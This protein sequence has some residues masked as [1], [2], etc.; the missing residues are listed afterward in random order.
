[1]RM[2]TCYENSPGR[3]DRS[4]RCNGCSNSS[5]HDLII[6]ALKLALFKPKLNEI[7]VGLRISFSLNSYLVPYRG[8]AHQK[9]R[10]NYGLTICCRML[11]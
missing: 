9:R 6:M 11:R 1:M 8:T 2:I 10:S 3:L 4:L 5:D 7:P